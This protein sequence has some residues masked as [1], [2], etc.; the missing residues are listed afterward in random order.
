MSN[1][2]KTH[3][4][5]YFFELARSSYSIKS[6]LAPGLCRLTFPCSKLPFINYDMASVPNCSSS[7]SS[8]AVQSW[9]YFDCQYLSYTTVSLQQIIEVQHKPVTM[10]RHFLVETTDYIYWLQWTLPQDCFTFACCEHQRQLNANSRDTFVCSS[11][12]KQTKPTVEQ[13]IGRLSRM[14]PEPFQTEG[15]KNLLRMKTA[16]VVNWIY[17]F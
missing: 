6:F 1:L 9:F 11:D 7:I 14:Y 15:N 16:K 3:S 17:S 13:N 8:R 10:F 5:I 4:L 2:F 12:T